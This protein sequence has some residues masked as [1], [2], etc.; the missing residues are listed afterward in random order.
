MA[1]AVE[2]VANEVPTTVMS[3]V[4]SQYFRLVKGMG[5][6]DIWKAER[7]PLEM[8]ETA[9]IWFCCELSKPSWLA[10]MM[11]GVMRPAV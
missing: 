3:P 6:R 11:G 1:D 7:I 8:S 9:T 5:T 2:R 4:P 10:K